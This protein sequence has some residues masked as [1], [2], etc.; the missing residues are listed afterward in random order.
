MA[1]LCVVCVWWQ[2]KYENFRRGNEVEFDEFQTQQT[3]LEVTQ[4]KLTHAHEALI[5]EKT[6]LLNLLDE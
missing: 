5:S 2:A 4:Q 1:L 3:D 6:Y